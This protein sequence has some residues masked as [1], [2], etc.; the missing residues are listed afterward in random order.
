MTIYYIEHIF[1]EHDMTEDRYFPWY[2]DTDLQYGQ[3]PR[4]PY[5]PKLFHN[6]ICRRLGKIATLFGLFMSEK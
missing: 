1:L 2:L 3:F 6:S 4:T 5:Y